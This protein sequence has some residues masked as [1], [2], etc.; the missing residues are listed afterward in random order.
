M[1]KGPAFHKSN[2]TGM[3]VLSYMCWAKHSLHHPGDADGQLC[4]PE[5]QRSEVWGPD[6]IIGVWR[7]VLE[8]MPLGAFYLV[9]QSGD[10]DGHPSASATGPVTEKM[11]L[12]DGQQRTRALVLGIV[13]PALE[14]ARAGEASQKGEHRCLWVALR[15]HPGLEPKDQELDLFLTTRGQPFGYDSKGKRLGVEERRKARKDWWKRNHPGEDIDRGPPDHELFHGE[16]GPPPPA[17][18]DKEGHALPLHQVIA[19]W[20]DGAQNVAALAG[21]LKLK[22]DP[23]YPLLE[24]LIQALRNLERG[25]VALIRVEAPQGAEEQDDKGEWLLRLFGRIG[26]AGV[27]LSPAEQR[28]SIFKHHRTGSR[29]ATDRIARGSGR[30]LA[31]PEIMSTA[32]RIAQAQGEKPTWQPYDASAFSKAMRSDKPE[33]QALQ[34]CLDEL[35]GGRDGNAIEKSAGSRGLLEVMSDINAALRDE[36]YNGKCPGFGLPSTM[37]LPLRA[38]AKEVLAYWRYLQGT[39]PTD[40]MGKDMIRFALAWE[41]CVWHP[42]KAVEEAF[43][44]LQKNKPVAGATSFP[45]LGLL[46]SMAIL[47]PAI[48]K[49]CAHALVPPE[50]LEA[51]FSPIKDPLWKPWDDSVL[52]QEKGE[53]EREIYYA[54]RQSRGRLIAWLQRDYLHGE[55]AKLGPDVGHENDWPLDLDHLQPRSSFDFQWTRNKVEVGFHKDSQHA[56]WGIGDA[57]GN[58]AWLTSTDNRRFGNKPPA[59]KI[60]K[61]ADASLAPAMKCILDENDAEQWRTL[62]AVTG[63]QWSLELMRIFQHAVERRTLWLYRQFWHRAGF[64]ALWN[65][66]DGVTRP[67]TA[68]QPLLETQVPQGGQADA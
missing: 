31:P 61:L 26:T 18:A 25:E 1:T 29:E 35:L 11:E 4:I 62:S 16:G 64:Q 28:F 5:M 55:L 17:K 2:V 32:L 50:S 43:K 34:D 48:E 42:Q 39:K 54:W 60:W 65:Y 24:R 27:P 30:I 9:P 8:G 52:R 45:L 46:Q 51:R 41:L 40:E 33:H 56:R 53:K 13:P 12:L 59:E 6:R 14:S 20:T 67:G 47:G 66:S 38:E 22:T 44:F 3:S 19:A 58:F 49:E 36:G 15:K 68:E 37:V 7:S 23:P 21:A 63:Q 57:I 10:A